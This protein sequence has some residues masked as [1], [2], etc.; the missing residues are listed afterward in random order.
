[1]KVLEQ[2][3]IPQRF[4][5]KDILSRNALKTADGAE[6]VETGG[7]VFTT[8]SGNLLS[9]WN[10]KITRVE[11]AGKESLHREA[12]EYREKLEGRLYR[13]SNH[14]GRGTCTRV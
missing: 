2:L 9:G 8:L 3:I 13:Y 5:L 11:D 12:G 4:M 7:K 6:Y 1:M 14:D 10:Q